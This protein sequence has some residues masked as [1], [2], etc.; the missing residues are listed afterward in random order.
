MKSWCHPGGEINALGGA[1]IVQVFLTQ[2]KAGKRVRL[3]MLFPWVEDV[4]AISE[5][6]MV[7]VVP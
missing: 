2:V 6:L 5:T 7:D 1:V 4:A 3:P